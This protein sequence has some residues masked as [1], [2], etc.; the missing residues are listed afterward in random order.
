[1]KLS[2]WYLAFAV[3]LAACGDLTGLITADPDAPANVTYQ[4]IPSG[5]PNAPLAVLLSWDLP[6]SGRANAFNV[7]GRPSRNA[8]WN[9]RATTTSP[10]FHDV[11]VPEL[12]YYVATRDFDGE[13]IAESEI[14]TIDL[15]SSRLPAPQGLASISLNGAVQLSWRPNAVSA[16]GATFDHYRVYSAPYDASRSV[17]TS[18]WSIEGSTVAD[19]FFV[20]NLTNGITLC[21]AVSAVT[22][23][24]HESSWSSERI[25]TPRLDARNAFVYN[26]TAR[27]D[28]SGFLFFEDASRRTGVVGSG[29]RTDLDFIIERQS[30]G[31]LWFAPGRSGVTMMLYSTTP[32]ADL[33][34]VD[35]APASGF[36]NA[37]IEA[38]PGFAY[39]FRVQKADGIH[40][41]AA[42]IAFR[43][44]DYVV[45]DWAYQSGIGN[46]EL[47]RTP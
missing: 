17:C 4:L 9:L 18:N 45:F 37:K 33:T 5:D 1:M 29:A 35:R 11:G 8:G 38:V 26:S 21:F 15:T 13:E 36:S 41:A 39:V 23:A 24:G 25:D 20:G 22:R 28:S 46:A 2:R 7:Y 42:R 14:V 44:N 27:R 10:S 6:S 30:D 31:S 47:N 43:T 16:G 3:P 12:Q 34:S 40:Y 19:G 32:V